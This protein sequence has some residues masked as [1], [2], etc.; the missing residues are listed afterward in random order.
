MKNFRCAHVSS[1]NYFALCLLNLSFFFKFPAWCQA[2]SPHV[3]SRPPPSRPSPTPPSYTRGSSRSPGAAA[4][5]S[6][7][8][9]TPDCFAVSRRCWGANADPPCS[10]SAADAQQEKEDERKPHIKKPLNAFMLYMRDERPKVV[11]QCKVKESATINQILGQRVSPSVRLEMRQ[12]TISRYKNENVCYST[13][14][15]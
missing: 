5:A 6:L 15:Y 10:R 14:V 7:G 1:S 9:L 11:A 12:C 4:A 2:A 8:E 3:W 13:I